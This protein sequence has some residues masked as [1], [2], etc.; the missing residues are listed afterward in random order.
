MI[1]PPASVMHGRPLIA[2]VSIAIDSVDRPG[3]PSAHRAGSFLTCTLVETYQCRPVVI[4][5]VLDA[6][7][8]N[9]T[10]AEAVTTLSYFGLTLRRET[11]TV[12]TSASCRRPRPSAGGTS[13]RC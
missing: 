4:G 11:A 1:V 5:G 13:R 8:V 9:D 10:K 7:N 12:T 3:H 2:R 6:I